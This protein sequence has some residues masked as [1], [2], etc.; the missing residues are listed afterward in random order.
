MSQ[1]PVEEGK[2][3]NALSPFLEGLLQVLVQVTE[4]QDWD[5]ANLR[6]NAYEAINML[7]QHAAEDRLPTIAQLIPLI[8]DRL[9]ASIRMSA[10]TNEEKD[11]KAGLQGLLCGIVQVICQTLPA[12]QIEQFADKIMMS[13]LQ[14]FGT[15]NAAAHE[16][17][18]MAAG[19]LADKMEDKFMR[20]M[21]QFKDVV[22]MGLRNHEEF[23]VCTVAVGVVG[24]LSRALGKA[25]AQFCNEIVQALLE[26]LQVRELKVGG[27]EALA[28][29]FV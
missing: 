17:A 12:M 3:S 21:V 16:E 28:R 9:E 20:Y 26:I 5:E 24:D 7:I 15:K 25:L 14:V 27:G 13:L 4:R 1:V 8:L 6:P 2:A 19:A 11:A 10:L 23:Q 29:T 22:M 18:L